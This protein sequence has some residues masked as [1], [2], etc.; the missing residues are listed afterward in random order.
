MQ[1]QTAYGSTADSH[2]GEVTVVDHRRDQQILGF[3]GFSVRD[4]CGS[5][6]ITKV[7]ADHS[8]GSEPYGQRA[9]LTTE[10]SAVTWITDRTR[11]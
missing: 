6:T 2:S 8:Q 3:R 9:A 11:A 4:I 5:I 10:S 1:V 7:S